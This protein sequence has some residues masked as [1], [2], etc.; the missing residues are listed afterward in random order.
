MPFPL[1]AV[2]TGAAGL[3]SSLISKSGQSS[4]NKTNVALQREQREWEESLSNTAIQ[5]RVQDFKA[6]GLNPMLAYQSE[7][8]TPSVSAA[9]VENENEAFRDSADHASSAAQ[10]NM[11]QKQ[12]AA[13]LDNI[14]A[15]TRQKLAQEALAKQNAQTEAYET[16]IR[17]NTAG[18]THLLTAELNNRV[19]K[20]RQEVYNL[21]TDNTGKLQQQEQDRKL[22]PLLLELQKLE[23]QGTE[24]GLPEKKA[25]AEFWGTAG[26]TGKALEMAGDAGSLINAARQVYQTGRRAAPANA[27]SATRR[28]SS[29]PSRRNTP[30][31]RDAN[32]R[33][34]K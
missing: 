15:D 33:F 14:E 4:A 19:N 25:A 10:L 31:K 30:R 21:I 12:L 20:L 9:K 3:A 18:N 5:R 26:G 28:K 22:Y 27:G 7:A 17:A 16:A 8:S 6:A 13:T 2:I 24:L 11:Q 23:N 1:A 29:G 32:G 34:T